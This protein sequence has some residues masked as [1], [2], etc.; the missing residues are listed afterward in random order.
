MSANLNLLNTVQRMVIDF[1]NSE[2]I[3]LQQHFKS[4]D[5]FKTFIVALIIKTLV[6]NGVAIDKAYDTVMGDGEY[7][8]LANEVWEQA[9]KTVA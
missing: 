4:I 2:G 8:N 1:A 5:Q 3:N 9:Q 7:E 6:D